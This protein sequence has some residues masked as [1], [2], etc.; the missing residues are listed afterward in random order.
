MT[1]VT[2]AMVVVFG[3]LTLVFH[4]DLF[5]KWKVTII[6]ALFAVALLVS[7]FVMKQTLIQKM[8]GKE[9]TLPQSVWGN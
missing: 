7:Q 1:L 6:Y 8:L 5:I 2:F 4:N 3:S 9:L